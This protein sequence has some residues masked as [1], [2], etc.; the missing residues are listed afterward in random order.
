MPW[1]RQKGK[2]KAGE[3]AILLVWSS[4]DPSETVPVTIAAVPSPKAKRNK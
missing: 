1:I 2:N 3:E 4:P